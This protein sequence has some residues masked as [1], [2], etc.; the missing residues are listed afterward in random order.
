MRIGGVAPFHR[1]I[2]RRHDN[3]RFV[4][5][6]SRGVGDGEELIFEQAVSLP[7]SVT[8]DQQ[9]GGD[10]Q[11]PGLLRLDRQRLREPSA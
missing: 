1:S 10:A 7:I 11:K 6:L 3:A 2:L 4:L 5:E 9:V 8:P